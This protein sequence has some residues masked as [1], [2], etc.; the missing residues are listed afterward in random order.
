MFRSV[1]S[2]VKYLI[3]FCMGLLCAMP[4]LWAP[5]CLLDDYCWR[6]KLTRWNNLRRCS[7]Y[8]SLFSLQGTSVQE[9][10]PGIGARRD[11]FRCI[12]NQTRSFFQISLTIPCLP[13][14]YDAAMRGENWKDYRVFLFNWVSTGML[15]RS[16]FVHK[17]S[18]VS[19]FWN[20][21]KL[22]FLPKYKHLY[23]CDH[24]I[25]SVLFVT[26]KYL[27]QLIFSG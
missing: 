9:T 19:N 17:F 16:V 18:A 26:R 3:A 24:H 7:C 13:P 23:Q 12:W 11:Q 20:I 6:K 10:C 4:C 21:A 15:S 25:G 2:F 8:R 27:V 1:G 5:A 22:K 14:S